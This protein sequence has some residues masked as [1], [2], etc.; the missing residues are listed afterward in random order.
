MAC[1]QAQTLF[2]NIQNADAADINT[3]ST[4]L[5]HQANFKA[6]ACAMALTSQ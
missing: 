1:I 2:T 4:D 3:K 6:D 5:D